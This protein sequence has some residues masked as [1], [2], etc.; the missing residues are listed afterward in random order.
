M[1]GPCLR[2]EAERLRFV[3]ERDGQSGARDFALRTLRLYRAAVRRGKDGH[4]SGY[5]SSY[6]RALVLSCLDFRAYLR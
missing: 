1:P 3:E 2:L 6:R 4:R 5:G